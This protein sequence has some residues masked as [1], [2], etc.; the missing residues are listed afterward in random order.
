MELHIGREILKPEYYE[1]R[2][3]WFIRRNK[4]EAIYTN[5][6]VWLEFKTKEETEEYLKKIFMYYEPH[7]TLLP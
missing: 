3:T 2:N 6:N 7:A 4:H 5:D 1:R